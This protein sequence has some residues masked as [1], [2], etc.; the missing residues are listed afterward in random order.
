MLVDF[1]EKKLFCSATV[2]NSKMTA[3][4]LLHL[5]AFKCINMLY[6]FIYN[7]KTSI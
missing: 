2:V 1:L 5:S 4:Y 7:N 3:L 6:P